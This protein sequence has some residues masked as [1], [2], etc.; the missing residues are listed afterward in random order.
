MPPPFTQVLRLGRRS[1]LANWEPAHPSLH[2]HGQRVP[3]AAPPRP[4]GGWDP[5]QN[6]IE[7]VTI[8]RPKTR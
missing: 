7:K 2:P 6:P 4:T 1:N 5:S 3:K 8:V